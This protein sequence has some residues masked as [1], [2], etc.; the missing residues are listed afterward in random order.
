MPTIPDEPV[1][2]QRAQRGDLDAFNALVLAY[3]DRLYSVAYRIMNDPEAAADATQEAFINAYHRISSYRGGSFSAWLVKIVTNSCYDALRYA[4]RRPVTSLEDLT[5]PDSD[6]DAPIPSD[7]ETPEQA[8]QRGELHAAIQRCIGAL[9]PDQRIALVLCDVEG[10][11]Y[12]EISEMVQAGLGTIKSRISRA[13][14][15]VRAC[16]QGYRDLLPLAY[17]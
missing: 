5:P 10:Y 6:D 8:A 9:Q 2:I 11:A 15:A 12:P 17:Q 4:K 3:Q 13:R 14:A 1:L 7:S 16:L